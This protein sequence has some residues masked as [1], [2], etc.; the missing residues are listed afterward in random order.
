MIQWIIQ[1]VARLFELPYSPSDPPWTPIGPAAT[2]GI[3]VGRDAEIDQI[4]RTFTSAW[5]GPVR[6]VGPHGIGKTTLM[7][8][9]CQIIA[10]HYPDWVVIAV[11]LQ[12]LLDDLRP[13]RATTLASRMWDILAATGIPLPDLLHHEPIQSLRAA[14]DAVAAFVHPSQRLVL[15]FD[16]DDA[17]SQLPERDQRQVA[18]FVRGWQQAM[19]SHCRMVFS[20][21][22]MPAGRLPAWHDAIMN[23]MPLPLQPLA[24]PDAVRLLTMSLTTHHARYDTGVAEW[25][26]TQTG[27]HPATLHALVHHVIVL[28]NAQRT[29]IVTMDVARMAWNAITES[30]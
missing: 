11:P 19:P 17:L 23:A 13:R 6:I 2:V 1:R 3:V 8:T 22:P 29:R 16:D 12:S 28:L 27:G 30:P 9:V 26:A 21:Q 10:A 15:W 5:A 14:L 4:M 18:N 24:L 7:Q 25:L 20:G